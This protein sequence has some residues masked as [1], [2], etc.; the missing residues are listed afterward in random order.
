MFPRR[1][2]FPLHSRLL[3]FSRIW[4]WQKK[5]K[6][7]TSLT[8]RLLCE[9]CKRLCTTATRFRTGARPI[10]Y[11]ARWLVRHPDALYRRGVIYCRRNATGWVKISLSNWTACR[12]PHGD[13]PARLFYPFYTTFFHVAAARIAKGEQE[14]ERAS[15]EERERHKPGVEKPRLIAYR[16][17]V[18]KVG[19][20]RPQF[21]RGRFV[22]RRTGIS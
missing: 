12:R 22:P 16:P 1:M 18:S 7:N 3:Q 17:F 21:L 20:A 9:I 10:S 19:L 8:S 2:P 15:E 4:Q 5:K 6:K 13:T 14:N 11:P